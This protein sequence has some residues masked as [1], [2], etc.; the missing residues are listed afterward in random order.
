[1]DDQRNNYLNVLVDVRFESTIKK[2]LIPDFGATFI[3]AS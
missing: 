3:T 1:M 2:V